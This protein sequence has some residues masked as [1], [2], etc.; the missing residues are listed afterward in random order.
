MWN[1]PTVN[2]YCSPCFVQFEIRE[3]CIYYCTSMLL[4]ASFLLACSITLLWIQQKNVSFLVHWL[5]QRTFVPSFFFYLPPFFCLLYLHVISCD[6]LCSGHERVFV[7]CVQVCVGLHRCV[8]VYMAVSR[9]KWLCAGV[10]KRLRMWVG[11]CEYAQVS[12]G[13]RG[14]VQVHVSTHGSMH[15]CAHVCKMN[16][17]NIYCRLES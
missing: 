15:V 11:M 13:M 3:T 16:F 2:I 8:Q 6:L 12:R 1:A 17:H 7:G 10:H 4:T 5:P 14:C 9:Y